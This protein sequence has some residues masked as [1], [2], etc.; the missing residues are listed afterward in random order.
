[1][2]SLL[3]VYDFSV[4]LVHSVKKCIHAY[5]SRHVHKSVF[6]YPPTCVCVYMYMHVCLCVHVSVVVI[7]MKSY[8]TLVTPQTVARQAPLSTGFPRQ[9]YWSGLPFP[10]PGNLPDLGIERASPAFQAFSSYH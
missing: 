1:M 5:F 8:L 7:V 9:E 6:L 3:L 4:V 2:C 10:S